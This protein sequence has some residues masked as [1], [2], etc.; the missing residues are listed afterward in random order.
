MENYLAFISSVE[1][2]LFFFSL[3]SLL[4]E[5]KGG[6]LP[7][8]KLP[9]PRDCTLG[10]LP[11]TVRMQTILSS[12]LVTFTEAAASQGADSHVVALAASPKPPAPASLME[13]RR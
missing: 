6:P 5:F 13:T 3:I 1:N 9:Q 4:S 12:L 10:G 7:P 2:C 11:S 8:R